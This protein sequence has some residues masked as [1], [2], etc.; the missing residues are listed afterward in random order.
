MI[1]PVSCLPMTRIGAIALPLL[2]LSSALVEAVQA[3]QRVRRIEVAYADLDLSDPKGRRELER[4]VE[5]SIRSVCRQPFSR[6]VRSPTQTRACIR[7]V[8]KEAV[9]QMSAVLAY[10]GIED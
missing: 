8:R 10:Q 9:A 6:S 5:R 4:R 2:L 1:D 7:R 3:E